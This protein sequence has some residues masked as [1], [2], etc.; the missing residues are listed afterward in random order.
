MELSIAAKVFFS[1][2]VLLI[3]SY[4][5]W[6]SSNKKIEKIGLIL[7]LILTGFLGASLLVGIWSL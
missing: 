6:I 5:C 4:V 1:C 2:C 7:V 3:P